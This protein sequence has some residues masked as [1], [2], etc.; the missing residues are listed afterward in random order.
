[1]ATSKDWLDGIHSSMFYYAKIR[2]LAQSADQ[3]ATCH[4]RLGERVRVRVRCWLLHGMAFRDGDI[5]AMIQ[6]FQ[7]HSR[8]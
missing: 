7:S 4:W 3:K 2:H 5:Q 1:M 6:P 8:F